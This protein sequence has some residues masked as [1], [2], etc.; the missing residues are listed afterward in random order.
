MTSKEK[1]LILV[2]RLKNPWCLDDYWSTAEELCRAAA[3]FGIN[4][5]RDE[6]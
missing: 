4:L 6:I 1:A 3:K 2:Q 5:A